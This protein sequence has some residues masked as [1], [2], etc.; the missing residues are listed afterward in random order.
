IACA[1]TAL[2]EQLAGQEGDVF[3]LS[4][5]LGLNV[6]ARMAKDPRQYMCDIKV[7]QAANSLIAEPNKQISQVLD[8][9]KATSRGERSEVPQVADRLWKKVAWD[10]TMSCG[11][12]SARGYCKLVKAREYYRPAGDL[13]IA[14]HEV[15]FADLWTREERLADG[16]LT[17]L[18][19][20]AGV[21][22]D[23]GHKVIL[24]AA[25]R[26]GAKIGKEDID[27]MVYSLEQ[28][29]GARRAL[30][31]SI[32]AVEFASINFFKTLYKSVIKSDKDQRLAVQVNAE[33]LKGAQILRQ[34]L[35]AMQLELQNEQEMHLDSISAAEFQAY[36]VRIEGAMAALARLGK[37]KGNQAICWLDRIDRSFW[38]V[39]RDISGLL[40]EHLFNKNIPVVFSSATLSNGGDFSYFSRALGLIEPSCSFVGSAFDFEEQ[41]VSYIPND[42]LFDNKEMWFS[43]AIAQLVSL[44]KLS[45]GRALILTNSMSEVR[46]IRKALVNYQFNFNILWE[47]RGERGYIVRRFREDVSSVLVGSGFWEGIDVPGEALSLLVIWQLPFP[48]LDPLI[49]VR[50]KAAKEQGMNPQVAVDYPEM[51]LKLKQG[52]GRLIRTKNDKGIIAIMDQFLGRPWEQYV[53]DAL[54]AGAKV[55]TRTE[56]LNLEK[57]F[58]C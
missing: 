26:A 18:P 45:G 17:L 29:Q 41:V 43:T 55:A 34:A 40:K 42:I 44:L 30:T 10:E 2:Q 3:T 57:K 53:R 31:S 38:V 8:W 39:P 58:F 47:D 6:D 50:R 5:L 11:V 52:C 27:S 32:M 25:M 12:C 9:A 54:P 16:K 51:G 13:I 37:D 33:L 56:E 49:E 20:Y 15:L 23:E 28:I 4:R 24:P 7:D 48:A 14:D 46:K 1:S 21:V 36:D 35:D 22:F 19:A